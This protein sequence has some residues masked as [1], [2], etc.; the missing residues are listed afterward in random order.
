MYCCRKEKLRKIVTENYIH[1]VLSDKITQRIKEKKFQASDILFFF[2]M[3]VK[4]VLYLQ[5]RG[6]FISY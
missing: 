1:R 3:I 4:I 2:T 5:C 6:Y